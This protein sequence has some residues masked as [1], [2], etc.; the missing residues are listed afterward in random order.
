MA[1]TGRI[2]ANISNIAFGII[3]AKRKLC[4]LAG[5]RRDGN[6]VMAST[7]KVSSFIILNMDERHGSS[8]TV[9]LSNHA[10]RSR[11]QRRDGPS[12]QSNT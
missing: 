9:Y 8:Y 5:I 10:V 4:Y 2:R 7:E 11:N 3:Q 6:G 1:A 12:D